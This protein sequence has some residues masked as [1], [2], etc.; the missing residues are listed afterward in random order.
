MKNNDINIKTKKSSLSKF[1]SSTKNKNKKDINFSLTSFK[2]YEINNI[3][4]SPKKNKE[5]IILPKKK[6]FPNSACHRKI[7]SESQNYFQYLNLI[8]ESNN[9]KSISKLSHLFKK[10]DLNKMNKNYINNS[11]SRNKYESFKKKFNDNKKSSNLLSLSLSLK[12]FSNN[13]INIFTNPNNNDIK[14]N[15]YSTKSQLKDKKSLLFNFDNLNNIE[16]TRNTTSI[17]GFNNSNLFHKKQMIIKE[18]NKNVKSSNYIKINRK[19]KEKLF[20]INNNL[21][22]KITNNN[23][24]INQVK[25]KEKSNLY[26]YIYNHDNINIKSKNESDENKEQKN[27]KNLVMTKKTY[28]NSVPKIQ[29]QRKIS[30][31]NAISENLKLHYKN[32]INHYELKNG[33]NYNIKSIKSQKQKDIYKSLKRRKNKSQENIQKNKNR[34]EYI[35][36]LGNFKSVEEIHFLFVQ[37]NQKKKEFFENNYN[38]SSFN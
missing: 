4:S 7:K 35:N 9:N 31:V 27:R 32:K 22:K 25:I 12:D 5:E 18:N 36:E 19:P 10:N 8:D 2:K 37:M 38:E 26:R 34:I 29:N 1:S 14:S 15:K 16:E 21:D 20:S 11:C 6:L 30:F 23:N 24:N 13:I 33:F 28:K 3:L 17:T